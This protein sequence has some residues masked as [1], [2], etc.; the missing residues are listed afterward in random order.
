MRQRKHL[1][2]VE[3]KLEKLKGFKYS[4]HEVLMN[5]GEMKNLEMWSSSMEEKMACF[6][7]VFCR[8]KIAVSNV[9]KREEAKI[10]HEESIIQGEMFRRMM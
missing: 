5:E 9:E 6:D 7:D 4:A 8:L 2:R 10:K 3:L 1:Q